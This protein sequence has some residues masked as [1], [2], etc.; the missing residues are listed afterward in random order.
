VLQ[1]PFIDTGLLRVCEAPD[2]VT[3]IQQQQQNPETNQEQ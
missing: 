3:N 1:I 2:V